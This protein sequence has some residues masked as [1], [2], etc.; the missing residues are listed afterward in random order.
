MSLEATPSVTTP[1]SVPAVKTSASEV[2]V[3]AAPEQVTVKAEANVKQPTPSETP[4][5][6]LDV[7]A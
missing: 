7:L 1:V 5:K 2:P 6:K 3:K 4:G